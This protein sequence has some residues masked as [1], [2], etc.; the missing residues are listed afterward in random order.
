[1]VCGYRLMGGIFTTP[2]NTIRD[3]STGHGM[4]SKANGIVLDK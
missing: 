3:P 2:G 4:Y 1:M